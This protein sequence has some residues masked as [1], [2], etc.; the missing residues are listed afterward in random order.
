MTLIEILLDSSVVKYLNFQVK[1]IGARLF[2]R[3]GIETGD[4][5]ILGR[6]RKFFVLLNYVSKKADDMY[7][8]NLGF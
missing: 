4:T 3:Y 7:S 5:Q 6:T 8:Y 1:E 2:N